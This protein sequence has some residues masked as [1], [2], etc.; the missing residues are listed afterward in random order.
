MSAPARREGLLWLPRPRPQARLRLFCF[1]HAGGWSGS[2]AP[3]VE[4]ADEGLE[5][6]LLEIPGRGT[7]TRETT[8]ASV[9]SLASRLGEVI[10]R[11]FE[12]G[13]RVAFLGH[14][15]GALVAYEV[16][17]WL[18][19]HVGRGAEALVLSSCRPPDQIVEHLEYRPED[20]GNDEFLVRRLRQMGNTPD[21]LLAHEEMR[22]LVLGHYRHDLALLCAYRHRPR[23]PL[24]AQVHVLGG[25]SDP[26]VPAPVLGGWQRHAAA[27]ITV[28]V[29]SGGHF[30]LHER[31]ADVLARLHNL[32]PGLRPESA[33]HS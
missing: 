7:C 12:D 25:S 32:L 14:S 11:R 23:P 20:L 28:D 17:H 21:E 16:Q 13:P 19:G 3:L 24:L 4:H 26:F 1:P 15:M 6:A 2:Y 22:E 30:H 5:L 29:I 8:A 31:A 18:L 10:A 27:P 33:D 9:E